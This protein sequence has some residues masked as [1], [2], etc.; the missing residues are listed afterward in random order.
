M[1]K[2]SNNFISS[3]CFLL[4]FMSCSKG[5]VDDAAVSSVSILKSAVAS[6][7][8]KADARC[9]LNGASGAFDYISVKDPSI[10]YSNS[11]Y[12]LFYTGRDIGTSGHWRMG[13]AK[14]S[15]IAGLKTAT[16][17]YMSSL[18][19]GSYFCAPQV[20]YFSTKGKW[21]LIYQSGLGATYSTNSDVTAYSGWAAGKA[22]GITDGI[23]FW[24]ISDGTNV[25]CF[26]SAQDGS[27]TIKRRST[28]IAN[29]PTGWSSSTAVATNTF[30]APHVY[31]NKNDGKY[32]M[33]VEDMSRYQ[34]LWT[35]SSLG[36]TWTKVAE[37]W[38]AK[39]NLT[40][41]A[42]HWTDQV[43]HVEIIRSGVN[44][45]ME[46]TNIDH[47]DMLIQGVVSGTYANYGS[48]PYDLGL[49]HNY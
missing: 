16:H 30:E 36:G 4:L 33:V 13:Y 26:Y 2:I 11:M 17:N 39:S 1:K 20:F 8:W 35:A 34:E 24:C 22:M 42:E 18:N 48:I 43:S 12:N 15:T 5:E 37:K 10:V 14:A 45:L 7:S 49:I 6:P 40:E 27:Y 32:Y 31:K 23:D 38:A 44:Q 29:F 28:T 19:G 3:L 46:I 21:Y 9:F 25:Y 41:T 47:C